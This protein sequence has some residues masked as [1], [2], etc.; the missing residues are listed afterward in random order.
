MC[1]NHVGVQPRQESGVSG[2]AALGTYAK[3]S[4]A[5]SEKRAERYALQRSA[6]QLR[7]GLR[8]DKCHKWTVCQQHTKIL[9]SV[10][11]GRAFYAGL[12]VCGS[13]WE[14]PVCAAK[15]SERR[16]VEVL[17]AMISHR[18]SGGE[19]YLLTL[20]NPHY[21]GDILTELLEGQGQALRRFW[22]TRS[23]RR[24]LDSISCLGSIRTLEVTHG[25]NGFHPHNHIL[26]FARSG[27]DLEQLK[28]EFY[29]LWVNACRLA[30]LPMPSFEHG[31]DVRGGNHAFDYVTKG[32]MT[33]GKENTVSK[34]WG[35]DCEMTK[36]HI[37]KGRK[38]SRTPF[39]LLRDFKGGDKQAGALFVE[40]ADA[41]KGKR[42][43]NWSKGLK[44]RFSV[45][46]ISDAELAERPEESATLGLELSR[47][48]WKAVLE[49]DARAELLSL[50]EQGGKFEVLE[51]LAIL[52]APAA[53]V[54]PPTTTPQK[55]T[56]TPEELGMSVEKY[57]NFR[58][59]NEA[60]LAA[61]S[62][63]LLSERGGSA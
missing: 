44:D 22:S 57:E 15:I 11:S 53:Y 5:F 34:G 46:E 1:Q 13:V 49:H 41:F 58:A 48:E 18:A 24:L 14:C 61:G 50:Y 31:V 37:K 45:E 20:T 38:E 16:R 4:P 55:C 10:D 51:A 54:A 9:E 42:Q 12:Q 56:I 3:Y 2:Q 32:S 17:S 62:L 52:T 25:S 30:G 27:L 43:L 7:R 35:L 26:I 8:V 60:R 63:E 47:E 40:Y 28:I 21:R 36:G 39:D 23:A 33:E 6:A 19:I 59:W 29:A